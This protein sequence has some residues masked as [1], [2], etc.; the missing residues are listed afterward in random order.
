MGELTENNPHHG[1]LQRPLL[2]RSTFLAMIGIDRFPPAARITLRE[3][4]KLS[5]RRVLCLADVREI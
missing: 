5:R 2:S 4:N 3:I 1:K